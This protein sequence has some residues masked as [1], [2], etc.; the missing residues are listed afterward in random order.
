MVQKRILLLTCWGSDARENLIAN[1]KL[2]DCEVLHCQQHEWTDI[3]ISEVADTTKEIVVVIMMNVD[4]FK[5]LERSPER[6]AI[7][8]AKFSSEFDVVIF[9]DNTRSSNRVQQKIIPSLS[10]IGKGIM[11]LCV[12][13]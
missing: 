2:D 1:G 3:L 9:K 7:D 5:R 11:D 13:A 6:F 8:F 10:R 12:A 4:F